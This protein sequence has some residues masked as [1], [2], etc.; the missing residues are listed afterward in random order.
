KGFTASLQTSVLL[1]HDFQT[2]IMLLVDAIFYPQ[3]KDITKRNICQGIF[4]KKFTFI[5]KITKDGTSN[6]KL[7]YSSDDYVKDKISFLDYDESQCWADSM[8][9]ITNDFTNQ[10]DNIFFGKKGIASAFDFDENT[11]V[12]LNERINNI[13]GLF[14]LAAEFY[15]RQVEY[16]ENNSTDC[17]ESAP[18]TCKKAI[19]IMSVFDIKISNIPIDK[20]DSPY[21]WLMYLSL[22]VTMP[23]E[24]KNLVK[25]V[26]QYEIY[27]EDKKRFIDFCIVYVKD[28]SPIIQIESNG[29]SH[30]N[31]FDGFEEHSNRQNDI[32]LINDIGFLNYTNTSIYN[33]SFKCAKK[34]WDYVT[35]KLAN[36]DLKNIK[37]SERQ[38]KAQESFISKFKRILK[39]KI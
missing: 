5:I 14:T 9:Y 20:F 13:R 19:A 18:A 25:I 17:F 3:F 31:N 16:I 7:K 8:G 12:M 4:L 32:F 39:S 1:E 35:K 11:K 38:G 33:S 26:P 37:D 24:V 10:I 21:E 28:Q 29:K 27:V 2:K 36:F 30:F 34:V 15:F 6:M 22:L 23:D